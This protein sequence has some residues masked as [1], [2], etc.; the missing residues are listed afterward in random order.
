MKE[1][2]RNTKAKKNEPVTGL[3]SPVTMEDI[4]IKIKEFAGPLCESE[5]VELV[6]VE[7]RR[8]TGGRIIRLY[9]DKPGGVTLNDCTCISR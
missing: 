7:C 3:F 1:D 9:I 5:G 6:H 8:E 2:K 4:I